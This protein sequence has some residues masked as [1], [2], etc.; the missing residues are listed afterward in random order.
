MAWASGHPLF[1][2]ERDSSPPPASRDVR[3]LHPTVAHPVLLGDVLQQEACHDIRRVSAPEALGRDPEYIRTS[4]ADGRAAV[5]PDDLPKLMETS[6][7][8][9]AAGKAGDFETRL[10]RHDGVSRWFLM[11]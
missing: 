1:Q 6:L 10:R 9:V 11:S 7:E 3:E 4:E 2:Q 5:H 8:M